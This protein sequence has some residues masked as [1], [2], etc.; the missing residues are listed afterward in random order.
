MQK[1]AQTNLHKTNFRKIAN[2]I[3][4]KSLFVTPKRFCQNE[5][6][7]NYRFRNRKMVGLTETKFFSKTSKI[8]QNRGDTVKFEKI[9]LI[10]IKRL[11]H[12]L[13]ILNIPRKPITTFNFYNAS[14][15]KKEKFFEFWEKMEHLSEEAKLTATLNYLALNFEAISDLDNNDQTL[16]ANCESQY[17]KYRGQTAFELLDRMFAKITPQIGLAFK[18][19]YTKGKV[20]HTLVPSPKPL[21]ADQCDNSAVKLFEKGIKKRTEK[22][23]V[24]KLTNELLDI[25]TGK[26]A[27]IEEKNK[28]HLTALKNRKNIYMK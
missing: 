21:T 8:M 5:I 18:K 15:E 16:M 27:S 6:K 10:A 25:E 3:F 4:I 17:E 28:V 7:E 2:N 9:L 13:T 23:L 14:F 12:N 20:G 11:K 22:T 19:K 24:R 1:M 26:A